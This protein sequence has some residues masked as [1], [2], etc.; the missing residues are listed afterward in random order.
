VVWLVFSSGAT[1]R[2]ENSVILQHLLTAL[3]AEGL[4]GL[5]RSYRERPAGFQTHTL[6][7]IAS[8]ALML[9]T[10]YQQE[11]FPGSLTRVSLDPTRMAQGI[12]TGIGFLCAGFMIKEGRTLTHRYNIKDRL[13]EYETAI[14]TLDPGNGR[15][16]SEALCK[17]AKENPEILPPQAA[18]PHRISGRCHALGVWLRIQPQNESICG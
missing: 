18:P 11:W 17:D 8:S 2:S 3:V 7:R 5:E 9:V 12:M 14:R 10:V 13:F 4:I 1:W 15:T 16:L 6:A